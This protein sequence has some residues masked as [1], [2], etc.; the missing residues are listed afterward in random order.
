[1]HSKTYHLETNHSETDVAS[2]IKKIRLLS[3]VGSMSRLL[4]SSTRTVNVYIILASQNVCPSI[5]QIFIYDFLIIIVYY[6]SASENPNLYRRIKSGTTWGV[7]RKN[8]VVLIGPECSKF[9]ST[10]K[11]IGVFELPCIPD[12]IE[13]LKNYLYLFC[14][15]ADHFDR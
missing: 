3:P 14:R 2:P 10:F 4:Q 9:S 13:S 6:I 1:M 7:P 8:V 5:R 15:L 11:S 12:D